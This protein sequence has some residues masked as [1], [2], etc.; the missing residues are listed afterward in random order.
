[1][2]DG[3]RNRHYVVFQKDE[4]GIKLTAIFIAQLVREGVT[5]CIRDNGTDSWL[6]E[7]TGG[8]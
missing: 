3:D 8:Y 5:Y 4:T 6:V 2:I 1:M 7:L